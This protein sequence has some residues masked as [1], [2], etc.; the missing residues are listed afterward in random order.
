MAGL[1]AYCVKC[2]AKSE[3]KNHVVSMT[4]R[5]GYMAKGPCSKCG[6][7]MAKIMSKEQADKLKK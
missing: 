2:R 6:T 4:S 1:E 3:M 5:G 7:N